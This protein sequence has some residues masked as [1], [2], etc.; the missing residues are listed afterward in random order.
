MLCAWCL[1]V[2]VT[3]TISPGTKLSH[4]SI[5]SQIA[6][7]GMGEVYLAQDTKLERR[8]AL[9]V[10]PQELS[11]NPDRM[12]RFVQEAKAAAALNHPNIA[13]IYEIGESSGLNFIVMEFIDGHTLREKLQAGDISTIAALDIATQ[14]AAALSVAHNAGIVHRDIKPENVMVTRD[15]TVKVLDFGLA[16]LSE[17]DSSLDVDLEAPTRAVINTEPGLVMGTALYMSPEQARGLTV[18]G[19][20]D[21][22][23]LGVVVYELVAHRLPFEGSNTNEILSAILSEREPQPL[24]RYTTEAPAELQRIVTKALRKDR[25]ERYQTTKDLLLDLKNLKQELDFEEKLQKSGPPLNVADRSRQVADLTLTNVP[26][27]TAED[28]SE[29]KTA[30]HR[31]PSGL[32]IAILAGLIIL[33]AVFAV[34]VWYSREPA[35]NVSVIHSIAVLPFENVTSDQNLEYLSDGVTESL[36]NSLSQ[37][38]NMRVIARNSVFSYKHQT[39][40][41]QEVARQLD[42]QAI[43]TGRVLLQG[44]TLDVRVELTNASNNAQLWGDHYVRKAGDIFAVQD[45]IARQV[46]DALRVRLTGEQQ[47]QVLKRYT[48]NLEA[49]RLYLQGRFYVNDFSEEQ[50]TRAI[51]CFSQALALDKNYALAYAARGDAYFQLGDLSLRMSDAQAKA[52]DDAL[53]ALRLD[54]NLVEALTILANLKFQYDWDFAGSDEGFQKAIAV[55]PN[56]AEAHHQYAWYLAMIGRE[57]ESIQEMK[58][59]Q[60]LDPVNPSIHVDINLPLFILRQYDQSIAASRRTLE[61]FPN[62]YIAHMTLGRALF[63]KGERAEGIKEL[64]KATQLEPTPHLKGTLAFYYAKA[65]RRDDA[66]RLLEELKQQ[67]KVRYVASYWIG[68]IYVGLNDNDE[69]FRWFEKAYQE[70]SWWLMFIKMDPMLDGVRS[71]PRFV[72]LMRRIGFPQ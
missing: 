1:V 13:H 18:D 3:G 42:V 36:I 23:S 35:A 59:A 68:M 31:Y 5:L 70:R 8:V 38:P 20:T 63:A 22:F 6:V 25:D 57:T 60:Q 4:Y 37:L 43:L 50:L 11:S 2:Q 24:A 33:L 28:V 12:R 34:T 47:G 44:D 15:G 53:A 72:D 14:V 39:P 40:N 9:K 71:D 58:L 26:A 65:N 55:N 45:E 66:R 32:K 17:S 19:R 30:S 69:A 41:L 27:A 51:Q 54:D 49:Y 16:K 64:E 52:K 46:T 61:L 62:F 10:L 67:S 29:N 21:I 56:Y 48:E 7:G